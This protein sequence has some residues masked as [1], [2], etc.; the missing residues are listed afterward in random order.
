MFRVYILIGSFHLECRKNINI[1]KFR[2]KSQKEADI[3]KHS[4]LL[5]AW[6]QLFADFTA[7]LYLG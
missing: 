7:E 1:Q 5:S 3:A 4:Q 2:I 6:A